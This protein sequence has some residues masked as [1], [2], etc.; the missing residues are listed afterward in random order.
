MA[1]LSPGDIARSRQPLFQYLPRPD[2]A[3][4]LLASFRV[5]FS[6]KGAKPCLLKMTITCQGVH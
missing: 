5:S 2:L 3:A 4:G 6:Q 1:S